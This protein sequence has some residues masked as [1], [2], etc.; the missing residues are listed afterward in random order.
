MPRLLGRSRSGTSRP[1]ISSARAAV[2]YSIRHSALSRSGASSR[3]IAATCARV[4]ARVVSTGTFGRA[5]PAVGSPS[6]QPASAH[7]AS[8]ERSADRCRARVAGASP[9][10]A[11]VNAAS[12]ALAPGGVPST[13][14]S[15]AA[16]GAISASRPPRAARVCRYFTAVPAD[17]APGAACATT[18]ASAAWPNVGAGTPDSRRHPPCRRKCVQVE[19]AAWSR[20]S[21]PAARPAG[22]AR[23]GLPQGIRHFLRQPQGDWNGKSR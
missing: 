17:H 16:A 11:A 15:A 12:R 1:R 5:H 19:N 6:S 14:T 18:K 2:S 22:L 7:Q 9:P 3:Q 8:A 13:A 10:N 21:R 20:H 4:S 23:A